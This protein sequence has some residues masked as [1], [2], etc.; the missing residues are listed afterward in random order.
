MTGQ[1]VII[2]ASHAG[3]SCA[4]QLR[5]LGF[6]GGITLVDRQSGA[7]I[8]RPP[9]SKSYLGSVPEDDDKFLLRR[10]EWYEKFQVTMIDGIAVDRIDPVPHQI[11]L[12]N[13]QSLNYDKLILA[14]GAVPRTLPQA[15]GLGNV[16]VLR[17]PD[18]AAALRRAMQTA[19][20]AVVIGGG[21]IGL[22]AAASFRKA[23]LNVHVVE[24]ADR[25]LARVASPEM[26]AFF[27]DLH[28]RHGVM[29]HTGMTGTKIHQKDGLFTGI[30]LDTG[31]QIS[32]ELLVVGIG[33]APDRVLADAI[34]AATGNGI[35]VDRHMRTTIDDVYAIG[36]VALVDGAALRIESVHNAQDT[37][38]RAAAD[39]T[40][41]PLPDISVPWFWSEQYDMRLQSAGIV[42]AGKDGTHYA[43]RPSKREGG[44]SVWSYDDGRLVAVEAV[45]DPAA[46]MLGKKCLEN[47][48]SPSRS[49]I[50]DPAFDLKTFATATPGMQQ[51]GA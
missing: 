30:T 21:Y 51:D 34:G 29:I 3:I 33:V 41:T 48:L 45:Y 23:G 26:S 31:Q 24:A 2:G 25:L 19:N 47:H 40:K 50:T 42:P 38:A 22:E 28:Q 13:G 7:P 44:M 39:I 15:D 11:W 32:A 46:Y 16:H 4:E 36:D 18:D 43:V 35:L 8:E 6:S 12:P 9:L 10:P 1:I 49:D 5:T 37:A 14:T 20:T 27:Q 17:S